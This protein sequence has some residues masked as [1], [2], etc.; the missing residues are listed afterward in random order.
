MFDLSPPFEFFS[1][2]LT[3]IFQFCLTSLMSS[4]SSNTPARSQLSTYSPPNHKEILQKSFIKD[5]TTCQNNPSIKNLS[6]D[7]LHYINEYLTLRNLTNILLIS[8]RFYSIVK[9]E[10]NFKI[11]GKPTIFDISYI[12]LHIIKYS[13][14]QHI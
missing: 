4:T 3:Y 14:R 5:K 12:I 10:K 8:K 11:L 1:V 6:A 7:V 13:N 2:S 9:N